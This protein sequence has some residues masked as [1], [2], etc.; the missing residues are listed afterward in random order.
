[1]ARTAEASIRGMDDSMLFG[2]FDFSQQA[3]QQYKGQSPWLAAIMAGGESLAGN[4]GS[5]LS[6]GSAPTTR[7]SF[8]APALGNNVAAQPT[9]YSFG[10]PKF[11]GGI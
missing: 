10:K 9:T 4:A 8:G 3:E 6:T 5:L 7:F 2:N 11:G 1:M